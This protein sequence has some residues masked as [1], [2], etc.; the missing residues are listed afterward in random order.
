MSVPGKPRN[1]LALPSC[2]TA[3][4]LDSRGK[5]ASSVK[6]LV[7]P[8]DPGDGVSGSSEVPELISALRRSGFIDAGRVRTGM[9][10]LLALRF[11][12]AL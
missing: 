4:S 3:N 8:G 2:G 1:D 12:T 5:S 10:K 9:T 7:R 6:V 11:L